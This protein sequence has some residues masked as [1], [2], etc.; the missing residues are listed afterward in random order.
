[1]SLVRLPHTMI[2]PSFVIVVVF[3]VASQRESSF[4][5]FFGVGAQIDQ[6][7]RVR[8][9]GCAPRQVCARCTLLFCARFASPFAILTFLT[10]RPGQRRARAE[11]DISSAPGHVPD[12]VKK[13]PRVFQVEFQLIARFFCSNLLQLARAYFHSSLVPALTA[14]HKLELAESG[15]EWREMRTGL[16]MVLDGEARFPYTTRAERSFGSLVLSVFYPEYVVCFCTH[17]HLTTHT[18]TTENCPRRTSIL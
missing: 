17:A 6:N 2:S 18:H 1:M 12:I 11:H 9:G 13:V 16:L 5:R 15:V 14:I 7:R 3:L 10:A 4:I 8:R